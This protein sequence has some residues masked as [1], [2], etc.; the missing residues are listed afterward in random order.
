[1]WHK[2]GL[3]KNKQQQIDVNI[4]RDTFQFLYKITNKHVS[5]LKPNIESYYNLQ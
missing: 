2:R 1:M 3:L 5:W 4:T